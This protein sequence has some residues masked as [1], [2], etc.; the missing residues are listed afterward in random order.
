MSDR[1]QFIMGLRAGDEVYWTDPVDV[2]EGVQEN[3]SSGFYRV[4]EIFD[5]EG[6]DE[7]TIVVLNNAAGS[8]LE[9]YMGELS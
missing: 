1:D 7:E 3:S 2:V 8:E 9:A 5:P 4:V 6:R